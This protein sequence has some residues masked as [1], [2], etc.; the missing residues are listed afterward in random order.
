MTNDMTTNE[1]D[2][3]NECGLEFDADDIDDA[4]EC[5]TC[6]KQ[7]ADDL[8]LEDAIVACESE[9]DDAQSEVEALDNDIADLV[10]QLE[11]ARHSRKAGVRRLVKAETKLATL[12]AQRGPE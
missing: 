8:A 11:E 9:R 3:C 10:A 12:E 5:P 4:G 1:I 6:A 2:Y 7:T